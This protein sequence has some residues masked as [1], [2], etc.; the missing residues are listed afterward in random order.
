MDSFQQPFSSQPSTSFIPKKSLVV[1]P[2]VRRSYGILGPLGILIFIISG[3]LYGGTFAYDRQLKQEALKLEDQLKGQEKAFKPTLL[4]DLQGLSSRIAITDDLLKKHV[5]LLPLLQLLSAQ[6]IRGLR[7]ANMA[8][9]L[10]AE[11]RSSIIRFQG[12]ARDYDTIALQ[13]D[14]FAQNKLIQDFLFSHLSLGKGG[15][16]AFELD[17]TVDPEL[18]LYVNTFK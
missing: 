16:V 17:L 2:D 5:T 10:G 9:S 15:V 18:F 6:T 7:F 11:G 8:Y 14:V 1:K 4:D 3:A 13:S 12:E